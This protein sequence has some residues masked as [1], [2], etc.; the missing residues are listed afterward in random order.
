MIRLC[1]YI[2]C[3]IDISNKIIEF[4]KSAYL[5]KY[6]QLK[7]AKYLN[8]SQISDILNNR[9]PV[10]SYK[11]FPNKYGKLVT[12]AIKQDDNIED[13]RKETAEYTKGSWYENKEKRDSLPPDETEV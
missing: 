10:I 9:K 6:P 8:G 11:D 13:I 12:R 5:D 1:F 2:I 3:K 7:G 4:F